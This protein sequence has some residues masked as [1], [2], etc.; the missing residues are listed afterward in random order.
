VKFKVDENLESGL[1]DLLAEGGHDATT[2]REEGLSGCDDQALYLLCV[3]ERR[4]LITLDTEFSNPLRFPPEP[5]AGIVVLR[6]SRP[7]LNLIRTTL[8]GALPQIKSG[9]AEGKLWIVEPGLI[10]IY[11][12]ET[13]AA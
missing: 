13:D 8:S 1:A 7:L 5:T 10:R 11:E 12:P 6:P 9:D 4:T 3:S 2:V